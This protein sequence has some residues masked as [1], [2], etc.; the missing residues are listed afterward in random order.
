[1]VAHFIVRGIQSVRRNVSI[2]ARRHRQSTPRQG[3]E[4]K[5]LL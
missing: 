1:M 5:S 4:L 2:Y 3:R